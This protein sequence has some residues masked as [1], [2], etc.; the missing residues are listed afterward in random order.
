MRTT[1]WLRELGQDTRFALRQLRRAPGFTVVAAGTL[2]LGIGANSAMF[3]L[4][5]AALLRPLPYPEPD[6][7]VMLWE[8]N[9][10]FARAPVSPL[11]LRDWIQRNHSFESL[12]TIE[13]GLGGG[14]LLEGADGSVES[15]E[16]Q[17]VSTRFFDVL[18]VKPVAGRLFLPSD[19]GRPTRVIVITEGLWRNR[20]GGDPGL[21]GRHVRLNGQ[22][23]TVIG[24]VSDQV[25]FARPARIWS[26]SSDLPAS[27]DQR[28][29]RFLD[30]VGRLKAGATV[31]AARVDLSAIA[32][33]LAR[34][35]PATNKDW[36]IAIEPLRDGLISSNLQLTSLL[37]SG[38]VACVL[39]MCCANVAN[40]LLARAGVRGRE[41]ALR[42]ALGAGRSRIVRQLL[43]ESLVLAAVSAIPG[44]AVGALILK[45]AP[46]F[47]P[48]GLLPPAVTLDFDGRVLAFCAW[49]AV[50]AG[51]LFGLVP[52]W[53]TS[54]SSL[55]EALA[56]DS[57]STTA[58][59]RLRGTIAAAQIA[60]AVVLLCGAGLL[61]R[62]LLVLDATS[63]G[64][65]ATGENVLTLDLSVPSSRYPPERMLGFFDAVA[66]D[67][68]A[69]PG[70]T[71]TGWSSTLP[72][73]NTEIGRFPF[74][75]A[76]EAPGQGTRPR[77]E[78]TVADDGY[79]R[80]ADIPIVA[81]RRF[82]DRDRLSTVPV[83]IVNE[84]FARRYLGGRDP[85]GARI[86]IRPTFLDVPAV[87]EVV[88][89]ARQVSGEP[90]ERTELLQVYVPLAQVPF[91]EVFL[92]VRSHAGHPAALVPAIRAAAATHDA[93]LPVR[94]PR[95]LDDLAGSATGQYRFRA[96]LITTFAALALLVSTVGVFGVLAYSVQQRSREFSV[97]LAL[98]ASASHLLRL[99]LGS[100]V[101]VVAGGAGAG[102]LLA[103]LL[104]RSLSTFLFGVA[105]LDPVTYAAVVVV[106]ALTAAVAVLAP[107]LRAT[108]I[109]PVETFR[110]V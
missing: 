35:H 68:A 32:Q 64:Y 61:L 63:A 52:A 85:I 26:L 74:E 66:R 14:P 58:S 72:W 99:V 5:D 23:F 96:I 33:Q 7:L 15:V 13:R 51:I 21:I 29:Q 101:P 50:A 83:C 80:T 69:L 104:S 9:A 37:L 78:Y 34:E 27:F 44:V 17:T 47:M 79:F 55:V 41:V 42:S 70:V 43:T 10:E 87:R 88:G 91:G 11:N 92:L 106:L 107:A 49:S 22:P 31:E 93:N 75:I 3:S 67:V 20:F 82:N 25:H 36:G 8:R 53:Q 71:S 18:G 103:A 56:L 110:N 100:A 57:R 54:R 94:R 77:A 108:R 81:G 12:A 16:R 45:L 1:G 95:T 6:R 19:E 65:R 2:A 4:A 105:P 38:A 102:L 40:L 30:V 59:G 76:G 86:S 62:T 84:A 28:G 73:G 98:G 90:D 46:A 24:V 48:A 97:R 89:I 60:A 109:D 39:L